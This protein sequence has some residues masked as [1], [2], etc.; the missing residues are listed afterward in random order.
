MEEHIKLEYYYNLNKD[1]QMEK[2]IQF[3]EE[4]NSKQ[5]KSIPKISE[6]KSKLFE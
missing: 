3:R 2:I 5:K 1:M 4:I 6:F